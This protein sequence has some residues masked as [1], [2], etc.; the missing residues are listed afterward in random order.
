MENVLCSEKNTVRWEWAGKQAISLLGARVLR[1]PNVERGWGRVEPPTRSF[2]LGFYIG[3][4]DFSW[5]FTLRPWQ[6]RPTLKLPHQLTNNPPA[7][8]EKML[9]YRRF[10]NRI[11]SARDLAITFLVSNLKKIGEKQVTTVISRKTSK[12][13]SNCSLPDQKL[14]F[15]SARALAIREFW[16]LIEENRLRNKKVY[17]FTNL[18]V[19]ISSCIKCIV[20]YNAPW[21]QVLLLSVFFCISMGIICQFVGEFYGW[22]TL[23]G[24]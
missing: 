13:G 20:S 23:P 4:S 21:W 11:V 17:A 8:R 2:F 19:I 12:I 14:S 22:T 1:G 24:H 5:V 18:A 16:A 7:D 15:V 3:F 10:K 6:G 9:K